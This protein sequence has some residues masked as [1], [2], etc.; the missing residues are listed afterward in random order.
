MKVLFCD[1][2][3]TLR[4]VV[5]KY[6]KDLGIA[7]QAVSELDV[8]AAA[9]QDFDFIFLEWPA[10]EKRFCEKIG[11]LHSRLGQTAKIVLLNN[12][13]VP[14]LHQAYRCGVNDFLLKP[15]SLRSFKQ[16]LGLEKASP[17]TDV[18]PL[19]QERVFPDSARKGGK[20]KILIIDDSPLMRKL[21]RQALSPGGHTIF[22]AGSGRE[23]LDVLQTEPVDL[24][25]LD[26]EMPGMDGYQVCRSLKENDKTRDI[27]VI[28]IST[29][30]DAKE[31]QKG[32]QYGA[33]EYYEKPFQADDLRAFV[34]DLLQTQH[35]EAGYVAI[36]LTAP[37]T[38]HI[39]RYLLG[40]RGHQ[41]QWFTSAGQFLAAQGAAPD[42]IIMDMCLPDMSALGLCLKINKQESLRFVPK[43]VLAGK[44][45]KERVFKVL[46]HGAD[47]YIYSPFDAVELYARVKAHLRA[48]M[49]HEDLLRKNS[50][51]QTLSITDGLT[52]LLN[53]RYLDNRLKAEYA[54]AV[55]EGNPLGYILLD[56]DDFKSVND[57]FG[58]PVGDQLLQELAHVMNRSCRVSDVIGRYGG[59]EFA[60]ILPNTG[61]KGL[62]VVAQRMLNTLC[63]YGLVVDG[64]KIPISISLGLAAFPESVVNHEQALVELA[65][66]AL[67]RA[68]A[69]GKKQFQSAAGSHE[70]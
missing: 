11:D 68:K 39:L 44:K 41:V 40:K 36:V 35:K 53:R 63:N 1:Q 15:F 29:R 47:D 12:L 8:A 62:E 54:R 5:E 34:E 60:L 28:I 66:K 58:H 56:V 30:T 49:L 32:F 31:K 67:Y 7:L 55:R 57:S 20:K 46:E 22:T 9:K 23:A 24:I 27:P 16:K 3:R 52:G 26:L 19:R 65:D 48:R 45:E 69:L 14:R 25:T 2:N 4:I 17:L 51:L 13:H 10:E 64:R 50:L 38:A 61:Y 6:A 70:N 59:D 42:L 33:V 37:T 43:I 21:I 18:L